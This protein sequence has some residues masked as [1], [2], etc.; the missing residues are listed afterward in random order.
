MSVKEKVLMLCD[1]W[2]IKP[3]ALE[4]KAGIPNATIRRWTD[5]TTSTGETL[6]KIAD[7]FNVSVDWLLDRDETPQAA[8]ITQD[9]KELLDLYRGVSIE[10]KAAILTAARAFAGQVDYRKKEAASVTA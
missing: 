4:K 5:E 7:F 1:S 9:E 3:G 2:K 8:S 6:A 10:G